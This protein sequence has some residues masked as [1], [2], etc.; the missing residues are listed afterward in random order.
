MI[1]YP[2]THGVYEAEV[3]RGLRGGA[4]GGRPG[5]RRRGQPE[6]AGRGGPAGGVRRRRVA[7]E[8]AQDVLHPARRRRPGRRPGRG[9]RAPRAVPAGRRG[10]RRRAR[11]R[12]V[13]GPVRQPGRAADLVDVRADDGGRR[14]A[15]GDAARPWRRRTT[16]R[17]GCGEHFPVLYAGDGGLRRPRVH[18]RPAADHEDDGR[19][20]R[21]RGQAAGRLRPARADDVVPG[22][23]H[24]DGGADR[25]RGPRRDR[26][27]RRRDDRDPR[28]DRPGRGGGVAGGRQPAA[29]RPA[30]RGLPGRQVGP[31]VPARAR[32]VPDGR[33]AGRA[34]P[35]GV[36]AGAAHRRRPRRPQPRLLLPAGGGVRRAGR[37]TRGSRSRRTSDAGRPT[38][39]SESGVRCVECT[40]R[41][42]R[43]IHGRHRG[44]RVSQRSISRS[45]R[46]AARR[47]K[48]AW[49]RAYSA[50]P[51]GVSIGTGG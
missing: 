35:Q 21:R 29:R 3:A 50:R 4:R 38:P 40:Q 33:H 14:A 42:F 44:S 9:G 18:P 24:A 25:E 7:P 1:T 26:P 22:G 39:C 5:L 36:A 8:P 23:G 51:A 41:R 6:R 34:R 45:R 46:G 32:R 20:G 12:R 16:S 47:A 49:A 27:V 48:P 11:R 19:D 43:Y 15:A 28:G 10:R 13:G 37:G 31:P 2:S 17:S 30:H